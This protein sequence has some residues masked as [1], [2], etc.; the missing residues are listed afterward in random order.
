ML[1]GTV[2]VDGTAQIKGFTIRKAGFI[3]N[4][5]LDEPDFAAIEQKRLDDIEQARQK[6]L[7]EETDLANAEMDRKNK[8]NLLQQKLAEHEQ[9]QKAKEKEILDLA[10][11]VHLNLQF[12]KN[13]CAMRILDKTNKVFN[14]DFTK[15]SNSPARYS[16]QTGIQ[17]ERSGEDYSLVMETEVQNGEWQYLHFFN[18]NNSDFAEKFKETMESYFSKCR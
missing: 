11:K 9:E 10:A 13:K 15:Y 12:L 16:G 14:F 4:G 8:E 18:V 1:T 7:K 2:K 6:I 5:L 17:V 3:E